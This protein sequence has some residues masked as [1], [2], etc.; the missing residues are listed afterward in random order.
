M[1][2][3]L[4][5]LT[6][7]LDL[8]ID[9]HGRELNGDVVVDAI[10]RRASPPVIVIDALDETPDH[11]QLVAQLLVPLARARRADGPACRLLV[12]MRPWP[13]FTPFA[14]LGFWHRGGDRP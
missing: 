10:A 1:P 12:G 4:R 3:I 11:E 5:S 13:E 8:E 14:R 9:D 2:A 6:E 7:Q